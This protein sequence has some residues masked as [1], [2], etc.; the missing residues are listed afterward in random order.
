MGKSLD[1]VLNTIKSGRCN[2]M[3]IK[4]FQKSYEHCFGDM[5]Q[6]IKT[7]SGEQVAVDNTLKLNISGNIED[8][9]NLNMNVTIVYDPNTEYSYFTTEVCT[10]DGTLAFMDQLMFKI[11]D[12]LMKVGTYDSSIAPKDFEKHFFDYD[13]IYTVG[14]FVLNEQYGEKFATKEKPWMES[15]FIAM[16]PIKCEFVHHKS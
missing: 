4:D 2:G 6:Y 12:K 7:D 5:F 8:L 16:L 11:L 15:Q 13:L 14:D 3:N 10:C 9:K 1:F